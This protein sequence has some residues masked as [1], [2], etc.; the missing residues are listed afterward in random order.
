MLQD[1]RIASLETLVGRDVGR[2]IQEL[3]RGASG[4]L[5]RAAR[6]I[7]EHPEP[8]SV[9]VTGV[10]MPWANPPAAE[11]DGPIG[12][13]ELAT[14]LSRA[15]W[16][17]RIVTDS[18]C[19]NAARAALDA[20]E[21][22]HDVPLD[23]V[24]DAPDAEDAIESL[25]A[26]YR[27]ELRV[28]HMIAIERLGPSNDG[29]VYDM[30]GRDLSATTAPLH[31]LYAGV[32]STRISIGDGG[33]EIGMGSLA[34]DLVANSVSLGARI[35]CVVPCDHLIVSGISNWGAQAL[36]AS[37][38]ILRQGS[39]DELLSGLLPERQIAII[40]ETVLNGPAVDGVTQTQEFS[41]DGLAGPTHVQM[42]EK[43]L[44]VARNRA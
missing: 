3:V 42:V 17:V 2:N 35:H 43:I 8:T 19:A 11:T 39:T 21:P 27:S 31:R 4:G 7:A 25:I 12:A 29:R 24:P 18:R 10:F 14:G 20:V 38:A 33:N 30:L 41:V 36:L 9:L 26:H 15:G 22:D 13:A 23:V 1:E 44:A 34:P 32:D 37:V 28:T 6:S 16:P 5:L 40:R